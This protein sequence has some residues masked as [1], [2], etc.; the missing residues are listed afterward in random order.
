MRAS[1]L[2]SS[3]AL[4]NRNSRS[5]I[6][7]KRRW[8]SVGNPYAQVPCSSSNAATIIARTPEI[9]LSHLAAKLIVDLGDQDLLRGPLTRVTLEKSQNLHVAGVREHLERVDRSQSKSTRHQGSGVTREGRCDRRRHKR[10]GERESAR[11]FRMPPRRPAVDREGPHG[12][13]KERRKRLRPL[14]RR[15][16]Q[17]RALADSRGQPRLRALR[18]D[19]QDRAR[20]TSDNHREVSRSCKEL[21]HVAPLDRKAGRDPLAELLVHGGV[22]LR[23]TAGGHDEE[24]HHRLR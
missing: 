22:S 10:R 5:S 12:Y 16:P 19:R 3:K 7:G 18:S 9:E 21:D 11:V 4:Q 24:G 6:I 8:G 23:E 14:E 1:H 20:V 17:G 2:A 13:L 15:E